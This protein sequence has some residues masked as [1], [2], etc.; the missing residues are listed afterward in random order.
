MNNQKL[1]P[2]VISDCYLKSLDSTINFVSNV[3][4][5]AWGNDTP[6]DEWDVKDVVN[7]IV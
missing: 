7:H 5:G 1:T 6:C 3:P 2:E 4:D